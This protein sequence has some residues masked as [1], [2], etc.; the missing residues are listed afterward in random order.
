MKQIK[1]TTV[2]VFYPIF[3][4]L[5]NVGPD[6]D[7]IKETVLSNK[8]KT[9]SAL[10]LCHPLPQVPHQTCHTK[11][12]NNCKKVPHEKC[13]TLKDLKCTPVWIEVP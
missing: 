9:T 10:V 1:H 2:R 13:V 7:N 4:Q 8:A 5:V 6:E 11:Y 3:S 12:K